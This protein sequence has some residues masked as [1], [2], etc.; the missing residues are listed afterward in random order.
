MSR[1]DR[2]IFLTNSFLSEGPIDRAI[3]LAGQ[4]IW[5]SQG[6]ETETNPNTPG[7]IQSLCAYG[8]VHTVQGEVIPDTYRVRFSL[9][10]YRD[11]NNPLQPLP[12]YGPHSLENTPFPVDPSVLRDWVIRANPA[13]FPESTDEG[14][15]WVFKPITEGGTVFNFANQLSH[16]ANGLYER[17]KDPTGPIQ[18]RLS[19][20]RKPS[21]QYNNLLTSVRNISNVE[22]REEVQAADNLLNDGQTVADLLN[23]R[24]QRY[25]NL[26]F[27]QFPEFLILC[28]NL[29]SDTEKVVCAMSTA[30]EN[31]PTYEKFQ[32]RISNPYVLR[33]SS[34]Q[35]YRDGLIGNDGFHH[36]NPEY[37][38]YL[39]CYE[40]Q[41]QEPDV[42]E[43]ML[44]NLYIH[45]MT[46]RGV[47][48]STL[49]GFEGFPGQRVSPQWLEGSSEAEGVRLQSRYDSHT[50]LQG[51]VPLPEFQMDAVSL[52]S[53]LNDVGN[54]FAAGSLGPAEQTILKSLSDILVFA[55]DDYDIYNTISQ[56]VKFFP[57]KI[58]IQLAFG[59]ADYMSEILNRYDMDT[60]ISRMVDREIQNREESSIVQTVGMNYATS[61]L[62]KDQ[63]AAMGAQFTVYKSHPYEVVKNLNVLDLGK[64]VNAALNADLGGFGRPTPQREDDN[65]LLLSSWG[66]DP[67]GEMEAVEQIRLQSAYIDIYNASRDRLLPRPP[68][69][70]GKPTVGDPLFYKLEKLDADNELIQCFY[71]SNK[72]NIRGLTYSDI[73]IKYGKEYNYRLYEY[74]GVAGISEVMVPLNISIPNWFYDRPRDHLGSWGWDTDIIR[75][76]MSESN[77]AQDYLTASTQERNEAWLNRHIESW[78]PGTPAVDELWYDFLI[79]QEPVVK[80]VEHQIVGPEVVPQ[81]YVDAGN[82]HPI[83]LEFP[84]VKVLDRPPVAPDVLPLALQNN[85]RQTKVMVSPQMG[86]YVGSRALKNI[87][88]EDDE[89][90]FELADYQREF[91]YY[92][93]P[94][95]RLEFANEGRNEIKKMTIYTTSYLDT[96][97]NTYE[98]LYQS[99]DPLQN[100]AATKV[101]YATDSQ[102]PIEDAEGFAPGFSAMVNVEPNITYY[103]TCTVGDIHGN[104]SNPSA[105][106]EMRFN[107][108]KGLLIPDIKL[109]DFEPVSNTVPSRKFARYIQIQASDIQSFPTTRVSED[110]E[111]TSAHRNLGAEVGDAVINQD[112]IIRLTSIDTGR[113]FD[114]RLSFNYE[115]PNPQ[116]D[117]ERCAPPL[118]SGG[119]P[120][121]V[122]DLNQQLGTQLGTR[123]LGLAVDALGNLAGG[124]NNV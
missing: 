70:V 86:R 106:Y 113:K 114:L 94:S 62:Y 25:G 7:N 22:L 18:S 10:G 20:I 105:I 21:Q 93:L 92:Q 40:E 27:A 63:R 49:P 87:T 112:F 11:P 30:D 53:Y 33:R 60:V 75:R 48:T 88:I 36:L 77:W 35:A 91:E 52:H 107:Y 4:P 58:D 38:Y 99:F 47:P 51:S 90:R 119:T 3:K 98:D 80:I 121:G 42:D 66:T 74:V 124:N 116:E 83:G 123:D 45:G 65:A 111:V 67:L 100:P 61:Y 110:G 120:V 34:S 71:F 81:E 44:P 64:T 68:F 1:S 46:L 101:I 69:S 78:A 59:D 97:V 102:V 15:E 109:Y 13:N 6:E 29:L 5:S 2:T 37:H 122:Q 55:Q 104:S 89:S 84:T 14:T 39:E 108:E 79:M 17:I 28:Y 50:T 103:L 118:Q 56:N 19:A 16:M 117:P 12:G 96:N 54:T 43:K 24:T 26:G 32:A 9:G 73:Q 23:F 85:Y 57:M 95:D 82:P 72:D 41:I 76:A 31:T 8:D 115:D